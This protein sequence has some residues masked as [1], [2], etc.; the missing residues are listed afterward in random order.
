LGCSIAAARQAPIGGASDRGRRRCLLSSEIQIVPRIEADL[1]Q[2]FGLAKLA[3]ASMPGWS[4]ER[5]LEVLKHDVIFV[6]RER[7][8]PA[9]YV[10]LRRDE[11]GVIV[12]EQLFV[13]PGHERRGIGHQLLAY[14]EG[15][16]IADRA[17]SLRIVVEDNNQQAQSFYRRSGFVP[18][19]P[20]LLELIL[21]RAD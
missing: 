13:A 8:Q 6:A 3:F 16:A 18:I 9:G 17:R 4:D 5:V 20:E 14:A 15:Y 2:L 11:G 1:P 10:A 7:A 19:E 12:V 21:P